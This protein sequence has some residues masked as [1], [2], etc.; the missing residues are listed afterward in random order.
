MRIRTRR[1]EGAAR[2]PPARAV[3]CVDFAAARPKIALVSTSRSA[4][5][6]AM[7]LPDGAMKRAT[8]MPRADRDDGPQL[9]VEN[10]GDGR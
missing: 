6:P 1:D 3:I 8:G 4:R 7:H 9:R 10:H 5:L 2:C